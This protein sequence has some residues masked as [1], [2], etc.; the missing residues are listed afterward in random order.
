MNEQQRDM[1]ARSL[2]R[3]YAIELMSH[4]FY[5]IISFSGGALLH[6]P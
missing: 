3:R 4:R 5:N 1:T 2:K 6:P